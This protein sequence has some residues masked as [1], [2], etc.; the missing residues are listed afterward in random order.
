[1][2]KYYKIDRSKGRD[3]D[4]ML[5]RLTNEKEGK[6]VSKSYTTILANDYRSFVRMKGQRLNF[7]KTIE[8][9]RVKSVE[10]TLEEYNETSDRLRNS[11]F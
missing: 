10:I 9:E 8:T 2:A 1:M 6:Y 4:V 7:Q 3:I 5:I 11:F